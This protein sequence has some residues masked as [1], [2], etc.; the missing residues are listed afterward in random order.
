[1]S[2]DPLP[3]R[4][5][6]SA[7]VKGG[8]RNRMG[9]VLLYDDTLVFVP[10]WLVQFSGAFGLLGMF[11]SQGVAKARATA[12]VASGHASVLTIPVAT[13]TEVESEKAKLGRRLVVRTALGEEFRFGGVKFER[14]SDDLTRVLAA[15]HR[16]VSPTGA[17]LVIADGRVGA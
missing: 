10:S 4:L 11:V 6:P 5:Q 17:G 1:M 9:T 8:L 7:L 3:I 12:K 2:A 15:G 14:W 16:T 13:I